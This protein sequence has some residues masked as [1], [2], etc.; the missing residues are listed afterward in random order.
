ML[1]AIYST[2]FFIS[3][4]TI[5]HKTFGNSL[6][7]KPFQE[8]KTT[9]RAGILDLFSSPKYATDLK[10]EVDSLK[11][12]LEKM[13]SQQNEMM[14]S[15]DIA[16][17]GLESTKEELR[18]VENSRSESKEIEKI[19]VKYSSNPDGMS[20][21]HYA[22]KIGDVNA[23]SLFIANGA[24]VNAIDR[25]VYNQA[26]GRTLLLT[27]LSRAAHY[28]QVEIAQILI[29]CGAEVNFAIEES[30]YPIY[31]ASKSGSADLIHLLIINGAAFDKIDQRGSWGTTPLHIACASGNYEAVVAL[32]EAGAPI[33]NNSSAFVEGTPLD[34][35]A[36]KL[37]YKDNSQNLEIVKS[38]VSHGATR[39]MKI[40]HDNYSDLC[41]V[42]SGYL[43][44]VGR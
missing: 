33:N 19:L 10:R 42:I 11:E 12:R 22:I 15:L 31:Y 8:L 24:D 5:P 28:N 30:F 34:V 6:N 43:K 3:I 17:G 7:E 14:A 35:A 13:E 23:V 1:I 9:P 39:N 37:K 18:N 32:I 4:F 38:L 36:K 2:L 16:K 40:Y 26:A 27:P 29:N 20:A 41:P 25:L 21:L 44:S